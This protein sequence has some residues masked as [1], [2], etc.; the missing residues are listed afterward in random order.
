[1]GVCFFVYFSSKGS[2]D[3]NIQ[4]SV[5]SIV[6]EIFVRDV[7]YYADYSK[8]KANWN[9]V[10][11]VSGRTIYNY[12]TDVGNRTVSFKIRNTLPNNFICGIGKFISGSDY[13]MKALMF[14][15][16]SVNQEW[17]S[18]NSQTNASRN[19]SASVTSSSVF[20]FVITNTNTISF[21]VDDVLV[22][23]DNCKT[24][25]SNYLRI[26]DFTATPLDLEYVIIL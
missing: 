13:Q 6:S 2:G 1:M 10:T 18:T 16:N 5:G 23:T 12:L 3:L 17:Y 4:C 24:S 7:Y 22:A 19:I 9:K 20:K 25:F 11:S 26:D 21:Y 15:N 14:R 8:I